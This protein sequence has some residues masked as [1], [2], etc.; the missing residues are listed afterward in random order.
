[1]AET[2][3]QAALDCPHDAVAAAESA[4]EA[5]GAL[6]TWTEGAGDDEILEPGPG[7]TPLWASVRLTALLPPDTDRARLAAAFPGRELRF[8]VVADRDWD[9]EWRRGLKPL[10]FGQRL[11][12]CPVGQPCPDP[13]GIGVLLEPGLAFGTGTHPTTALCLEWLDGQ[14][15]DNCS[16]LDFGCGSGILAIGAALH[17]AGGIDAV[18]IDESAVVATRANAQA[19]GVA[20]AAGLPDAASGLYALVLANILATPLTLLAPLLAG[21]VAPGG[22]L[23]LAGILERQAE[24]LRAAYAPWLALQVSDREDGWILMT[25]QRPA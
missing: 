9:A 14:N 1:M 7:A 21:H 11:W 6:V 5:E 25:A 17:G 23:V 3:L 20:V 18:D 13:A 22:H 8:S 10:R 12:V 15:L 2:W 4:F 16:V 19:N 24:A